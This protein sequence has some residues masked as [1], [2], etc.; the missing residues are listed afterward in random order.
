MNTTVSCR[1]K[2]ME[3][4]TSMHPH[5][6]KSTQSA[7]YITK[8]NTTLSTQSLVSNIQNDSLGGGDSMNPGNYGSQYV[9]R[10]L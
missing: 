2:Y 1:V 10:I 7:R 3:K 6:C 5:V 8:Y 9:N 4:Y